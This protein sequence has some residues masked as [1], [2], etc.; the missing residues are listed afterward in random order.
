[1]MSTRM[2]RRSNQTLLGNKKKRPS[3]NVKV[4]IE[5]LTK[6]IYEIRTTL[7]MS[8]AILTGKIKKHYFSGIEDI[9]LTKYTFLSSITSVFITNEKLLNPS[10]FS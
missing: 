7:K 4:K 6:S 8:I 10:F 5:A 2:E 1:M 9:E 3:I